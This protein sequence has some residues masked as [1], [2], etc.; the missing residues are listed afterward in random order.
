MNSD[1]YGFIKKSQLINNSQEDLEVEFL[2]GLRNI[3]PYGVNRGLQTNM[4]TL[5]DGYKQC[6]LVEKTVLEFLL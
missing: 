4:S 1:L 2:D 5:V 6:E 3:L